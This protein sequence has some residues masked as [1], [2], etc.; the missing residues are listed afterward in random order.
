MNEVAGGRFITFEGGEGAGKSTQAARLLKR[1]QAAGIAALATREPG[2]SPQAEKIRDVLLSGA[3]R[4]LG[5]MAEAILFSAA[6]ADHLARTI[7]PALA[8][9]VWVVCDRFADSTRVY[10]GALGAVAPE[11]IRALERIVV[12]PTRPDLTLSLDLP[13]ELGLARAS[14]RRAANGEAVDRFEAE[15]LDFHRSLR[16]AYRRIA[17]AEPERCVLVDAAG[18]PE[19]VAEVIWTIVID[20]L[21]VARLAAQPKELAHG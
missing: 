15:A 5:P 19:S 10:Q 11:I 2:G 4:P 3:A 17:Q 7:R 16:E 9:A 21:P 8:Q 13:P 6:R 14:A 12:G 18:E 20:R 1:L